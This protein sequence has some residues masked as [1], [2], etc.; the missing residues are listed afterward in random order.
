M[1]LELEL[2]L[3]MPAAKMPMLTNASEFESDI[4]FLV[5]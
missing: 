3:A 1:L 2:E 4:G 5:A